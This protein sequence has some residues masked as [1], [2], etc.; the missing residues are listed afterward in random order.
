MSMGLMA[1]VPN[2]RY[3]FRM[4]PKCHYNFPQAILAHTFFFRYVRDAV[5]DRCTHHLFRHVG[6]ALIAFTD[7]Q[8]LDYTVTKK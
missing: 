8:L 4:K 7:A 1:F 6:G 3:E 5:G 2:E